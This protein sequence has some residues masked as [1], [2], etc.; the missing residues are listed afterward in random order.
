MSKTW[1]VSNDRVCD[2]GPSSI[3]HYVAPEILFDLVEIGSISRFV[4]RSPAAVDDFLH[5][6]AALLNSTTAN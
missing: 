1:R 3:V 4:T 5:I 6:S 2:E